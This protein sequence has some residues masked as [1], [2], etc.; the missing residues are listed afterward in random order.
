MSATALSKTNIDIF[1]SIAQA[2]FTALNDG[3]LARVP[4]AS[5]VVFRAPLAPATLTGRTQVEDFLRP[6]AG[7]LGEVQVREIY[8]STSRNAMAV[9][10]A[11]G[12]LHVMDKFLIRDGQIVEQQNF[13]DP[14]P[15]LDAPVPGGLTVDERA[16]LTEKLEISRESLRAL[17]TG[18]KAEA[19]N[20]RPAGGGWTALE[21][22]EHLVVSEDLLSHMVHEMLKT[23]PNVSL[24]LELQGRDGVVVSAMADRSHKIKTFDALVPTGR[25][26]AAGWAL[27][28]FLARRAATLDFVRTTRLPLHYHAAP[29]EGAGLL[30]AYHWLLLIAAHTDRHIQQMRDAI[31]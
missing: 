30:D 15:V 19:L 23:T 1:E 11:A 12:P 18:T 2:Y 21:C 22:A 7:N 8:I 29:L 3:N 24:P 9:E 27:D 26:Q 10:A 4:W 17:L 14:R 5:D 28:A 20:R 16:L 6:I 31:R 13:Y 25:Y